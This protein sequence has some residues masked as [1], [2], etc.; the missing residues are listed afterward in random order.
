MNECQGNFEIRIIELEQKV[1]KI[2]KWQEKILKHESLVSDGTVEFENNMLKAENTKLKQKQWWQTIYNSSIKEQPSSDDVSN[3]G[4]F[5]VRIT[6][7][8]QRLGEI[9]KWM[10]HNRDD[11][12]K[13]CSDWMNRYYDTEDELEKYKRLVER[14][15]YKKDFS[16]IKK[17]L[18][19]RN[20]EKV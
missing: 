15:F 2:E 8:E 1:A 3:Q 17:T 18:H 10:K 9:E 20:S 5:E 6:E 12:G 16:K 11:L 4:N 19:R 7:L 13:T 14:S